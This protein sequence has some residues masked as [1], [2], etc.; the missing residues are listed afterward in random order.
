MMLMTFIQRFNIPRSDVEAVFNRHKEI[1]TRMG[2][3]RENEFYE[4][5]SLDIIFTFDH[6]IVRY[7]FRRE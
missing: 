4:L 7:Y 5:P 1:F 3:Y 2:V 6:D